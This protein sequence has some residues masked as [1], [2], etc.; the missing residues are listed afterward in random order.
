M[1][2]LLAANHV[3]AS[4]VVAKTKC[5]YRGKLNTIKLYLLVRVL[6]SYLIDFTRC[7]ENDVLINSDYHVIDGPK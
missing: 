4:R 1:A 3:I 2:D 6:K 7:Y 5:N